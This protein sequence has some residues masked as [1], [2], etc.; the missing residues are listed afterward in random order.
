MTCGER[1]L[2][3]ATQF[4]SRSVHVTARE[5]KACFPPSKRGNPTKPTQHRAWDRNAKT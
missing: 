2:P 5:P 3:G 1:E 4:V